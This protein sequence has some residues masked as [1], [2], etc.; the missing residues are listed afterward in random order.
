MPHLKGIFACLPKLRWLLDDLPDEYYPPAKELYFDRHKKGDIVP[1]KNSLPRS[2]VSLNT[3]AD[4]D[5]LDRTSNQE[6]SHFFKLPLELR[7]IVYH[8]L[9]EGQTVHL[10]VDQTGHAGHFVCDKQ[11]AGE[12]GESRAVCDCKVSLGRG[13]PGHASSNHD[14]RSV[15]AIALLTTCRRTYT[16]TVPLLYRKHSFHLQHS[17]HLLYI[18]DFLPIPRLNTIT[19]LTARWHFRGLPFF[20]LPSEYQRPSVINGA[21]R[22]RF[23]YREDTANYLK[24]WKII[25]KMERLCELHVLLFDMLDLWRRYWD[26]VETDLLAPAKLVMYPSV[27]TLTLPY[28]ECNVGVDMGAS[29]CVLL[30]PT[31]RE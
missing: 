21:K 1:Y 11:E 30:A 7:T 24:F 23:A 22:P 25:A 9:F 2:T 16:E 13:L 17:T 29:G 27:F 10:T 12:T 5:I 4:R 15:G 19:R 14:T 31:Q 3:M 26:S 28:F 8:Y 6:Q 20:C 18:G